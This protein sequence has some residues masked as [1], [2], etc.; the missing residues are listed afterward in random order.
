MK[1]RGWGGWIVTSFLADIVA[2]IFTA[3]TASPSSLH[4]RQFACQV[5]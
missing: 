2:A 3:I 1:T 5:L 4:H